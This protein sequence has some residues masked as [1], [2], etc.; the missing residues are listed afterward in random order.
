MAQTIFLACMAVLVFSF[1][2][3]S[4][5]ARV[6]SLFERPAL[7]WALPTI[8]TALFA[9]AAL[10][11]GHTN[12]P[13]LLA[14]LAYTAAPTLC[15]FLAGRGPAKKPAAL[16][17]LAIALLWLPLEFNVAA[18]IVPRPVQGFLHT[19]AYG[20]AILLG[21]I[22][23]LCFRAFPGMKYCLP[24]SASDIR[25]ALIAFAVLAPVLIAAGIPIGFIPPP[26]LPS[27]PAGRMTAAVA[28]V[29]AGTA[30]PE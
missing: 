25:L 11:A 21:L 14:V 18:P 30:L 9:A 10:V 28:I 2:S 24:R 3:A 19:A 1:F 12:T 22:L 23:F 20:V 13:L 29:F 17:F 16:D 5:Q 6:R 15:V 7:V 8:L 4:L 26:H 27:A